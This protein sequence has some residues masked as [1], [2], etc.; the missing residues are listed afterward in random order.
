M[1]R[2]RTSAS[3]LKSK[4][5]AKKASATCRNVCFTGES[6]RL[7]AWLKTGSSSNTPVLRQ[8]DMF[9][10]ML[11]IYCFSSILC[12]AR[13]SQVLLRKIRRQE[14]RKVMHPLPTPCD[15]MSNPACR[16]AEDREEETFEDIKIWLDKRS[17]G[18][19]SSSYSL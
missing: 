2:S 4:P 3:G 10:A 16:V 11:C 8:R 14:L 15:P 19:A 9:R 1:P 18:H 13:A 6:S 12:C 7:A 5:Y 17:R